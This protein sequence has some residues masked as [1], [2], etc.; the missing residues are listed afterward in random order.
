VVK[1]LTLNLWHDSGPYPARRE[2]VRA[3]IAELDPDVI[4][5]QEALRGPSFDQV[6]ELLDGMAYHVEYGL[7]QH[8]GATRNTSPARATPPSSAMR[9]RRAGRSPSVTCSRYPTPVT[10]KRARHSP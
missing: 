2:L 6:R 5:F 7:H 3:W 8:S 9:S 1:V 10:A 4:G